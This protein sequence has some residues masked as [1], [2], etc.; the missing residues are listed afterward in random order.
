MPLQFLIKKSFTLHKVSKE[1]KIKH[2]LCSVLEVYFV[3]PA[4]LC[5]KRINIE[6]VWDLI[7]KSKIM[8]ENR[9]YA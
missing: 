5:R 4:N 8:D 3:Y 6:T 9:T 1:Q 2:E 7:S